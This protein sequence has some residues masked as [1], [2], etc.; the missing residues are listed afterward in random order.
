MGGMA[1]S[2]QAVV[3]A[4][5]DLLVAAMRRPPIL[6][7]VY[8]YASPPTWHRA[9]ADARRA[10]A[11]SMPRHA[12]HPAASG[13]QRSDASLRPLSSKCHRPSKREATNRHHRPLAGPR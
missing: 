1:L 3:A 10:P 12:R 6:R 5:G 11:G 8:V 4:R 13:R 9:S 2:D 7:P